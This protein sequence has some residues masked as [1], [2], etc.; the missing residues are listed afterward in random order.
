MSGTLSLS[1]G[2]GRPVPA[3]PNWTLTTIS[4]PAGARSVT[5][6][7]AAIGPAS[8]VR[9]L[10]VFIAGRTTGVSISSSNLSVTVNGVS[11]T[12]IA[13][14]QG[15]FT[16]HVA[17]FYIDLPS[18]ITAN[19]VG[20]CTQD[21]ETLS[22]AVFASS[23]VGATYSDSVRFTSTTTPSV[24]IS[25]P[26]GKGIPVMGVMFSLGPVSTITAT[27][28]VLYAHANGGTA[29]SIAAFL[30]D[31]PAG[32]STTISATYSTAAIVVTFG[33]GLV[34]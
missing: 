29:G 28:G 24:T 32:G 14:S 12:F 7:G 10:Y 13:G 19:F 15:S 1:L 23:P 25:S 2:V 9:R 11:A 20:S 18:G 22:I 30:K 8:P 27:A 31:V 6:N 3:V 26:I 5:W 16:Y 17:A 21:L 33:L 4:N 34:Y